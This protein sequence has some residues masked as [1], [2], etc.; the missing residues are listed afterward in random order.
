MIRVPRRANFTRRGASIGRKTTPIVVLVIAANMFG[1]AIRDLL[2]PRLK[3]GVGSYE[4]K[5]IRKIAEKI[6]RKR[7]AKCA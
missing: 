6:A 5:K 3:G 7:A 2:D 4:S 1:D